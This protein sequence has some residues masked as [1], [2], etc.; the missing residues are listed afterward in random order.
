MST[1]VSGTSKIS[2]YCTH[3]SVYLQNYMLIYYYNKAAYIV[4]SN[5]LH[6]SAGQTFNV[7]FSASTQIFIGTSYH[8]CEPGYLSQY[9]VWLR[10][11][12]LGD[13]GSIPGRGRGFFL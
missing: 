2:K 9:N 5:I 10:T 11:R 3:I 13:R 1:W 7:Q 6:H 4:T 12:Q 8:C